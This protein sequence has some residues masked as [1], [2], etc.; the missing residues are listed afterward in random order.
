M[1][2]ILLRWCLCEAVAY[3]EHGV[4]AYGV[5]PGFSAALGVDAVAE[6]AD[7]A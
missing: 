4:A 5:G 1:G 7:L 2:S 3:G 6:V